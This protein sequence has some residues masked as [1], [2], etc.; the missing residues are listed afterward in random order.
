MRKS[1]ERDWGEG[2]GS[3]K[4]NLYVFIYFVT[5]LLYCTNYIF[6][7][8]HSN[9]ELKLSLTFDVLLEA[10]S[11]VELYHGHLYG[12]VL[13]RAVVGCAVLQHGVEQ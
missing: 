11:A 7:Q 9:L 4:Y 12:D 1:N 10:L 2:G 6:Y 8:F 13:S 3:I 5:L